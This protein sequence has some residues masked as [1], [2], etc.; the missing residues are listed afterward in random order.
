MLT[1]TDREMDALTRQAATSHVGRLADFAEQQF[2]DGRLPPRPRLEDEIGRLREQATGW[3]LDDD[4]SLRALLV[5]RYTFMA[6][7]AGLDWVRAVI[8]DPFGRKLDRL[9]DEAG[10]REA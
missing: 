7:L 5:L 3:R 6:D 4:Q 9:V 2:A 10:R 1:I 8:D